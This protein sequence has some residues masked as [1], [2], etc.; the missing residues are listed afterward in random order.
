MIKIYKH[1]YNS[2]KNTVDVYVIEAEEKPKTYIFKNSPRWVWETKI[3]KDE[4]GKLIGRCGYRM[5]SLS[6]DSSELLKLMIAHK[7][8]HIEAIKKSLEKAKEE[9]KV[10]EKL[11]DE[12]VGEG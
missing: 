6:P 9:K 3:H 5:F 7:E 10:F 11:F 2:C 12:M 1:E 4:I 8:K